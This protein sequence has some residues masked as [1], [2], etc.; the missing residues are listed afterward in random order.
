M[1]IYSC[2]NERKTDEEKDNVTELFNVKHA[3]LI[4]LPSSSKANLSFEGLWGKALKKTVGYR[5]HTTQ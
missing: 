5:E 2:S 1:R 4:E 3:Q